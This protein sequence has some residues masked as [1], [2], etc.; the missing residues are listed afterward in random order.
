MKKILLLISGLLFSFYISAQAPVA[1]FSANV[2]SGC[3]SLIVTFH[4]LSTNTPT[5]WL[6][7]FGDG[8]TST[9]QH[10]THN[11]TSPGTYNVS[12]TATNASG[13]NI[14]TL[15]AYI[16]VYLLPSPSFTGI[17]HSGCS[18]LNVC[19]TSTST[20]GNAPITTYS[21]DFGDGVS[22][23]TQ[24]PCHVYNTAGTFQVTLTVTDQNSCTKSIATPNFITV[25]AKPTAGFT[26]STP[27][28]CTTPITIS[29]TNTSTPSSSTSSWNF[30]D[31]GTSTQQ[32]PSHGYAAAGN[33]TVTLIVSNNG[34]TDTV[35]HQ[36]TIATNPFN[37]N[38]TASPTSGCM[39]LTV[40]F[41]D[42]SSPN[43]NSWSWNFGD[44]F[45]SN[46]QNPT[47]V[48]TTPGTYTVSL[49]A[50][51][52]S[53]CTNTKTLNNY[54]T[55]YALP[56][57]TFS[58]SPLSACHAPLTV[59]FSCNVANAV[60][61]QWSFGDGGTS[62]AQNPSHTYTANGIYNVTLTITDNHGCSNS[63]SKIGYVKISPPVPSF[64]ESPPSG[65]FPLPV[66]F[67]DSSSTISYLTGWTWSFGDGS[68]V[69]HQQNPNHTYSDTGV[70]IVT[71]TVT[72][73]A[74]CTG[75]ATDTVEVGMHPLAN[76][77]ADDTIGC[78]KFDVSFMDLSSTIANSWHW[79]FGDGGTSFL[80]NP[81]HTFSDT[82]YFDVMLV[83]MHNGCPDTLD[84]EDY[85]YVLPPKPM[86]TASPT[87]GC[88]YP[89]TVHFT[90]QSVLPETWF[91]DFGDGSTSTQ[92]NP[93]HTYTNPGFYSV[94]L[95][96]SNSNGCRDSIINSQYIKISEIIPDFT[97]NNAM[98]CQY[99]TVTFMS[100]TYTNTLAASWTWNFGDGTT[101]TG[102]VVNHTYNVPGTYSVKLNVVDDLGC[103]DSITKTA[104][105]TVNAL[106]SPK[107]SANHTVGCAP[108]TVQFTD[109]STAVAPAVLNSWFWDFGDGTTSTLQNPSHVYSLP[110]VYSVLLRVADNKGCDS[111]KIKQSYITVS[112]PVASFYSDTLKCNLEPVLFTNTSTG[113]GLVYQW[114]FGDG[115][116][117]SNDT[118]PSYN[119]NVT[120]TTDFD[121]TLTVIDTNGCDSTITHHV[122]I[123]RPVPEF[124][125]NTTIANCPPLAVAFFD[126][127]SSDVVEWFWTF[128]DNASGGNNH[129]AVEDPQH[130]FN[131]S[132]VYSV[133]LMV[134]NSDGCSDSIFK[135]DYITINGPIGSFTYTPPYGCAPMDV[136][137]TATSQS[138]TSYF[139]VFGDGNASVT[140]TNQTNH[141][142]TDGGAY[143]ASLVL[144]DTIHNCSLTL[145]IPDS[146]RVISGTAAFAYT[147]YIPCSDSATIHFT[148]TSHT[149][150]PA[151]DWHWD[152]G[153]GSSSNQQN[154][155]H[156]YHTNGTFDVTFTV[157]VDTCQFTVIYE[158]IIT[159]FIP[160]AIEFDIEGV[161]TCMPP[162]H[163]QF[164]VD[165][166]TVTDS[167]VNWHWDFGDG[168]SGTGLNPFHDYANTGSFNVVLTATF[169]NGCSETY[170]NSFTLQVYNFPNADFYTDT[171]NVLA[172][173]PISFFDNSTG[174]SLHWNWNFGDGFSSTD[175]NPEHSFNEAGDFYV[176]LIAATPNGCADTAYKTIT[177]L[178]D[179]IIPNVFTP[180]NDGFNDEF[181]IITRG[182]T[183][184]T[185]IVYNRWGKEIF[186]TNDAT[187]F[188]DGRVNGEPAAE[189]TYY[190]TLDL[191]NQVRKK[192]LQGT[193]TL[194]R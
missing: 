78:H 50:T 160:P 60:S 75:T 193:I 98:V 30:G 144:N 115:S 15:N 105:I 112:R 142:Y 100:T 96:V 14:K 156:F 121:V 150:Y 107:F 131:A 132:G 13:A 163:S 174:T 68:P 94:K 169:L 80:Q 129:S 161:S 8:I 180:N 124:Y 175:Q 110:G 190:Y 20:P 111:I 119:Y 37:A 166:N 22:G 43:P 162:L 10:P 154:P 84:L 44:G 18:P 186:V 99:N 134:T 117:V 152:F 48:Y 141:I 27:T 194:I 146:I 153:D 59:N 70:Y 19:F 55:V 63:L 85:I 7:N 123:S 88:S 106:P 92:Q 184:F 3:G 40:T 67:T 113:G 91:W 65:C 82:G 4:D 56:A 1:N 29:F 31:G 51:N 38:F 53:Q 118:N 127:S 36:V 191:N 97:Q 42:L 148:D 158:D 140:N 185:F 157:W 126:S 69:N 52:T 9:I 101:G 182:F 5:S 103:T 130:I 57:V 165:T 77:V 54:I 86:Y 79:E 114:D 116:P 168:S 61:W 149:T 139:W 21:W 39:S 102:F 76:F 155:T 6:W 172:N 192:Q 189:G 83:A 173:E 109:L 17:P 179:V 35:T 28:P 41:N 104:L 26:F 122:R 183:D 177:I 34:C 164:I 73:S 90:D 58:G 136:S 138:T 108:L 137:F 81:S 171:N 145:I 45:A 176:I 64:I 33:Y 120:Q 16:H 187:H 25:G 11:Y 32:N 89:L 143:L 128:G 167:V 181:R 71:L 24:N 159:I 12:L 72:D 23:N 62:N 133:T 95:V 74:G 46:A 47:H 87:I 188:W 170:S 2:T 125:S 147:S 49:T 178:D 135:P 66:Q 93:T 151:T